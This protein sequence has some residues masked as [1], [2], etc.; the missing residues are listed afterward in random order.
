[1]GYP[2]ETRNPPEGLGVCESCKLGPY[3]RARQRTGSHHEQ[4]ETQEIA[5]QGE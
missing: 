5:G 1:M 3:L 2:I 4:K